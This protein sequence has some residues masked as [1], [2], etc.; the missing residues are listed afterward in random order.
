MIEDVKVCEPY[1][2][3]ACK[4]A[5]EKLGKPFTPGDFST[6]G[7]YHYETGKYSETVQMYYGTGGTYGSK[8]EDPQKW[9]Q[10]RPEGYD[11]K[12]S[13]W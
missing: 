3:S 8:I 6:K 4:I 13:I 10:S 11:C 5:G 2:E 12:T 1:L 9:G 7:C